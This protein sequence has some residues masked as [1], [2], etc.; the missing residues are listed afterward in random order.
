MCV[1]GCGREIR[2]WL[3]PIAAVST[4]HKTGEDGCGVPFGRKG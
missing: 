3:Q 2:V 1:W 4:M